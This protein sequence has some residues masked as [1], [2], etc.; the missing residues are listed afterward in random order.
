[1]DVGGILL[2]TRDE[3]EAKL[4]QTEGAENVKRI[5]VMREPHGAGWFEPDAQS[6]LWIEPFVEIKTIWHPIGV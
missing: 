4:V 2:A 3:A 5:R 1:M 6:P